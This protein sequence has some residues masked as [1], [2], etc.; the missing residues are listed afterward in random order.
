MAQSKIRGPFQSAGL[1][2]MLHSVFSPA[3]LV[4]P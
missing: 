4:F 2:V 3:G 1:P